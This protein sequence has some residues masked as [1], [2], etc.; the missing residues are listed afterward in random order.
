MQHAHA[1]FAFF[2]LLGAALFLLSGYAIGRLR[3][4]SLLEVE[5]ETVDERSVLLLPDETSSSDR[6]TSLPRAPARVEIEPL[7]RRLPGEDMVIIDVENVE[8]IDAVDA[9]DPVDAVD[10]V[11]AVEH[12]Q[13]QKLETRLETT[14][15]WLT[16]VCLEKARLEEKVAR[17]EID[18]KRLEQSLSHAR[19]DNDA[20]R[21][22]AQRT[23]SLTSR[24]VTL[25]A[26]VARLTERAEHAEAEA[27]S[28]AKAL[29]AAEAEIGRLNVAARQRAREQAAVE[30][31]HWESE[32]RLEAATAKL[33]DAEK[34]QADADQTCARLAEELAVLRARQHESETQLAEAQSRLATTFDAARAPT[35]GQSLP[36]RVASVSD[37][38]HQHD[39]NLRALA[40]IER[41]HTLVG[42]LRAENEA[43]R[44]ALQ[45]ARANHESLLRRNTHLERENS[46]TR[47]MLIRLRAS[48]TAFEPQD[49]SQTDPS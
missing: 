15:K 43:L 12:D 46:Q 28:A 23:D 47:G 41:E 18:R 32:R 49:P 37:L 16:D 11:D 19:R 4:L 48:N 20:F 34:R 26:D 2:S 45:S 42:Q 6:A 44:V 40:E 25:Q 8:Y 29:K 30:A 5:F 38:R 14:E 13:T 9:V 3:Q 33:Q 21:E 24:Q 35:I 22:R 10:A 17:L 31:Q 1:I 27:R 7:A 36:T 39:R